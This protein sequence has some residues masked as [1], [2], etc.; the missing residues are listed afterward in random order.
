M[1]CK[2]GNCT[3]GN[4]DPY[5]AYAELTCEQQDAVQQAVMTGL[6]TAY[7]DR[8]F[9]VGFSRKDI[10][11]LAE[12]IL[13]IGAEAHPRYKGGEWAECYQ[14]FVKEGLCEDGLLIAEK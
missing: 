5:D 13:S 10:P 3:C 12:L 7:K 4:V 1:A 14:N 11:K 9:K 8:V 6:L 2:C